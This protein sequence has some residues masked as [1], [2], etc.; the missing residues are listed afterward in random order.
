LNMVKERGGT[1]KNGLEMLQLQ[2]ER[3]WEIWMSGHE[4]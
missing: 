1:T 2:A 4:I 3:S